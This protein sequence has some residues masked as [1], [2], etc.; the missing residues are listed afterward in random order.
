MES[1]ASDIE[2]YLHNLPDWQAKNLE[3][4]RGLVHQAYPDIKEEIKWGV[5]VFVHN[6]KV[7]FSIGSF[8]NHTKYNF[9][10]GA[11]LNDSNSLFNNGLES[12]KTR[13]IDLE[14]GQT[15][16]T[17]PLKDL[18]KQALDLAS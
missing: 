18:I 9:F 5:P 14:E 12:K 10:N 16:A 11:Q 6:S 4:F 13:S 17:A 1:P 7:V 2:E 15:V 3:D 8:K